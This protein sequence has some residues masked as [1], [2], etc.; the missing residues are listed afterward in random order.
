[1]EYRKLFNPETVQRFAPESPTAT[2][3]GDRSGRSVYV[4][5]EEIVL[6][7]NVALATGR[8]LLVRGPSGGG[9]SSLACN[10]AQVLGCR[11]FE[12]V[13][14]SRTQARDLL[15]EVDLL[16]RLQDAQ[17]GRLREDYGHYINPGVFW[18]A[19]DWIG[20][21]AQ[22]AATGWGVSG[23]EEPGEEADGLED[24]MK[25]PVDAVV[26][27]DEI[28]KADPDVPNNLLVPLGSLTFQVDETGRVVRAQCPPLVFLTTNEERQLPAA[29][30]R[31]CVE[32]KLKDLESDDLVRIGEAHFPEMDGAFLRKVADSILQLSSGSSS[33][34]AAE[35]LDTVRACRE[36]DISPESPI[37]D[38]L[39]RITV[40]KHGRSSR[41][42]S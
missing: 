40:W 11:Y 39:S 2:D 21:S 13:I 16:R 41:S 28:D 19:F 15:W 3:K 42:R 22:K 29:F 35:Y 27:L 18:W 7:V 10:V 25:L 9:K 24:G 6:A 37:W 31:R 30:L 20:A 36:L 26:L 4:Y 8:P 38:D 23:F 17:S 32:L 5:T 1:M 14:S 12:K 34:S 33:P